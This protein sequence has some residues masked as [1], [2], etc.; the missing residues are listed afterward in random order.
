MK[1]KPSNSYLF[2]D[3]C[4]CLFTFIS[5]KFAAGLLRIQR[6][7]YIK[8]FFIAYIYIFFY[9]FKIIFILFSYSFGRK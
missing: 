2:F 8:I 4:V 9:R 7:K 3:Y 1:I 6:K 5:C